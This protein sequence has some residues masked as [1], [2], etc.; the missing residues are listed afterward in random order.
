MK[1][2]LKTILLLGALSAILIAVGGA[3][4]PGYL[5]GFTALALLMNFGASSSRIG[6]SSPCTT[7]E[8]CLV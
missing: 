7:R 3:L 5:Y 4:G 2:P 8:R 6:L 1:S